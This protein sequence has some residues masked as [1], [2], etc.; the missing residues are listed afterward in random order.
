LTKYVL[1][2]VRNYRFTVSV[3]PYSGVQV[4]NHSVVVDD[5]HEHL[6]THEETN[7]TTFMTKVSYAQLMMLADM[8][9]FTYVLFY[10]VLL[11]SVH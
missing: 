3:F 5:I 11:I 9:N 1:Q 2:P 8:F 4:F 7:F 6:I 10:S